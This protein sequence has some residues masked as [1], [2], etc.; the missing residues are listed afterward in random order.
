MKAELCH[1]IRENGVTLAI[2]AAY[3]AVAYALWTL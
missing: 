3:L 2:L 1:Y